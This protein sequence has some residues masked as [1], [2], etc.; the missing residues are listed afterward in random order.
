[1]T[2]SNRQLAAH[3][4]C[5]LWSAAPILFQTLKTVTQFD[6]MALVCRPSHSYDL[7]LQTYVDH[8]D[9][10]WTLCKSL[11]MFFYSTIDQSSCELAPQNLSFSTGRSNL[12]HSS[13]TTKIL[14]VS[15]HV[16]RY[17]SSR[18]QCYF[19]GH[20]PGVEYACRVLRLLE[21]S[22]PPRFTV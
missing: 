21:V 22:I 7:S 8:L 4:T 10:T 14:R 3:L 17:T 2:R 6:L 9:P 5:L 12:A 19:I 13:W 15:A 20:A 16:T 11:Q 18:A 1:M